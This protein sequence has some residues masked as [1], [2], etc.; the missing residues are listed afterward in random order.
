MGAR[1]GF[2]AAVVLAS[3]VACDSGD[4]GTAAATSTA[5]ATVVAAGP[6]AATEVVVGDCLGQVAVGVRE[7]TMIESVPLVSCEQPHQLEVFA[8]FDLDPTE[9]E[10]DPPGAYPGRERVV[11][12]ADQGCATELETHAE[13]E[14]FGL[15]SLWPTEESWVQGDRAVA[16]AAF[17]PDGSAF[18]GPRLLAAG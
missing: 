1:T 9:L 8:A 11:D 14:D 5:L 10:T 16:C 2:A 6:V 17:L 15:I 3:L 12:A 13:P 4:A 7:R 18:A